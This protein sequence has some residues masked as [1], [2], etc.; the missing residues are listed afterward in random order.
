MN[1]KTRRRERAAEHVVATFRTLAGV[2]GRSS[3]EIGAMLV[4]AYLDCGRGD[5]LDARSNVVDI[6]A[7]LGHLLARQGAD[8]ARVRDE[9][10]MLAGTD[11][12]IGPERL[13][14]LEATSAALLA[15]L[16]GV[17]V[18][19]DFTIDDALRVGFGHLAAER[20]LRP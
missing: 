11:F 14:D 12:A 7:D 13:A 18:G 17:S 8:L 15:S 2:A 20:G 16:E 9:A 19:D 10:S 1:A 3:P 5:P 4:R 6:V